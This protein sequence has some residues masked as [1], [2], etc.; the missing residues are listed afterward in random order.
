MQRAKRSAIIAPI[1]QPTPATERIYISAD[2]PKAAWAVRVVRRSARTFLDAL[3][4]GCELSIVVTTDENIR[5]LNKQ[6]RGKNKATDVL[7]F[8]QDPKTGVLGDIVISLDTAQRQALEGGRALSDEITRLLAHGLLHLMGHDHE[9]PDEAQ[10]M[11]QAEVALLGQVG[12]VGEA[13]G[14]PSELEF[15][16]TRLKTTRGNGRR[17]ARETS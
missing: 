12:L 15:K 3:A 10:R 8:E 1:V 7:S 9:E 16:R 5:Q 14:H 4:P 2:H 13:L 11:A 6:W 17:V